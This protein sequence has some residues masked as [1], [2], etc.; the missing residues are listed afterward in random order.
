MSDV[1]RMMCNC[2]VFLMLFIFPCSTL[3]ASNIEIVNN[4]KTNWNIVS[5]T[6]TEEVQFATTELQK[7]L[8]EIGGAKLSIVRNLKSSSLNIVVSLHKDLPM[9]YRTLL[10]LQE[11]G[12]DGYAVVISNNPE[13]VLIVG[14]NG[15]GVIYGVYNFL[16]RL[17]CR[18]FYPTQDLSDAEVVPKM[19]VISVNPDSWTV[20]SPIQYRIY[21]GDAWFFNMDYPAAEK[22]LDWAMKN[23]YNAIGWQA[24]GTNSKRSLT[25]QYKD[26]IDAGLI[27]ELKKRGMF[28]HGPGHSFDQLLMSDKYF[29]EHPEWFGM[30]NGKRVPQ[31][32]FG[33][34]FCWSNTG[35]R[36]KFIK[37]AVAFIIHAPMIHIFSIW[38]FDGGVACECEQCK[39]EGGSN[40]VVSLMSELIDTLKNIR[41]DV[42][43]ETIGGYGPV[44][45]PPDNLQAINQNLRIFWAHWGRNHTI[46]YDDSGY[47]KSNLEG[48]RE[49]AKGGFTLCQYYTDNFAEPWVMG[50]FTRAMKSDRRYFLKNNIDG[51]YALTYSPGFWWNHSLN[52]YIA[53]RSFYDVTLDPFSI[54][55]DYAMHYFGP[56]A[57]PLIANY[58]EEWAKHIELSYNIRHDS[59]KEDRAM[60]AEE[61]RNW[62]DPAV[63]MTK[64]DKLYSYRLSKVEKLHRLAESLTEMHRL[65]HV[66]QILRSEN[67]FDQAAIVLEKAAVQTDSVMLRFYTLAGLNQGLIDKNEI[68]GFIKMAVKN[69]IDDEAKFIAAK[70][71]GI[72]GAS[73]ELNET[74]MLPSDVY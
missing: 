48:W 11:K 12:Y 68:P 37:N 45:T 33:A 4:S 42:E 19:N 53:G 65:H 32:I 73:K 29:N 18:W 52:G 21:N 56:Q 67:K 62:I 30:H 1:F 57:G 23:R 26:L 31:N 44:A 71:R 8:E 74:E 49:A 10:P 47:N 22:Q 28:I 61:R 60:L 39:K 72:R 14:A 40:L 9:K 17:G 7:Y 50:P 6:E 5:I 27:T 35:A 41:P 43:V 20:A 36:S 64:N 54:I 2:T 24:S 13:V 70:D 58:Y 34:Q 69:W 38:P 55:R 15:P 66:I 25:M 59:K 51:F 63:E 3:S 16:E 46:G